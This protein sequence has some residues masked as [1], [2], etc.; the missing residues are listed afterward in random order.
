MNREGSFNV[1]CI[2]SDEY[3]QIIDVVIMCDTEIH[4]K[5]WVT[6]TQ[7][8]VVGWVDKAHSSL[9][10]FWYIITARVFDVRWLNA[11]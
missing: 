9:H 2:V 1:T 7:M 6:K 11:E 5:S 8:F 3:T 4:K 10:P